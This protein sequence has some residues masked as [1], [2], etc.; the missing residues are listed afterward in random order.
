V[1]SRASTAAAAFEKGAELVVDELQQCGC[2]GR[3]AAMVEDCAPLG[4]TP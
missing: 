1:R 3:A 2:R 4:L